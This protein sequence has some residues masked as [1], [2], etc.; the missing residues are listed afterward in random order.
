VVRL[1]GAEPV[2]FGARTARTAVAGVVV[3]IALASTALGAPTTIPVP[4]GAV[5][6]RAA[7]GTNNNVSLDYRASAD[8]ITAGFVRDEAVVT[9]TAGVRAIGYGSDQ[10]HCYNRDSTS[11]TCADTGTGSGVPIGSTGTGVDFDVF[12]FDRADTFISNNVG[13]TRVF[14]GPGNDSLRGSSRQ[15]VIAPF[16]GEPGERSWPIEELYGQAGND[17][18]KGFAGPD[19]LD[20]GR[21]NDTLD[22]GKGRDTLQGGRGNDTLNAR[23]GQRDAYIICG[24][25]THDKAIIDK[26]DPKPVG[27]ETVLRH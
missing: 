10:E 6:L 5:Y 9:D 27:C 11:A 2:L 3:A 15:I 7:P 16:G 1:L 12:L 22:G 23:D 13:D 25:G 4:S 14:G 8:Q 20:G 26:V 24:P 18:L 19:V 17:V 21:G